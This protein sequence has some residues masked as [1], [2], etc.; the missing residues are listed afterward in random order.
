MLFSEWAKENFRICIWA[1]SPIVNQIP[2]IPHKVSL[3]H[4]T[5]FVSDHCFDIPAFSVETVKL[6]FHLEQEITLIDN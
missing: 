4:H 2:T 5:T 3:A 6:N 1:Q